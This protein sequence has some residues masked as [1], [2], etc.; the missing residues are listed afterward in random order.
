MQLFCSRPEVFSSRYTTHAGDGK[1]P[2]GALW[3]SGTMPKRLSTQALSTAPAAPLASMPQPCS[4]LRQLL[5][6]RRCS[7]APKHGFVSS[8]THKE[9]Q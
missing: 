9:K 4:S 5:R 6:Q 3:N 8:K 1:R 2:S 7:A